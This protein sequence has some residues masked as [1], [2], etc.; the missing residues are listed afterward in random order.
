MVINT[1]T[2]YNP[3]GRVGPTYKDYIISMDLT[4]VSTMRP[5]P[6][7][8]ARDRLGDPRQITLADLATNCPKFSDTPHDQT[9]IHSSGAII[10][11]HPI[12][13]DWNRCNPRLVMPAQMKSVGLPYWR[14]CG[15]DNGH[16][17]IF[18]PPGAVPPVQGIFPTKA[19]APVVPAP[20]VT[21]QP[22]PT[23]SPSP[24]P[25]AVPVA[26]EP[27]PEPEKPENVQQ[28]SKP[29][30]AP[31]PIGQ[32][33]PSPSN[34]EIVAPVN[35]DTPPATPNQ[36]ES[37]PEGPG[38]QPSNPQNPVDQPGDVAAQEPSVIAIIGTNTINAGSSGIVLPGTPLASVGAVAT[39]TDSNNNGVVV[40]VAS[41]GV[42]VGTGASASF[43]ASP[44]TPPSHQNNAGAPAPVVTYNG[45]VIHAVPGATTLVIKGQTLT[46]GGPPVTISGTDNVAI[47][48]N[49]GLI[50]Q[51]PGGTASYFPLPTAAPAQLEAQLDGSTVV[52]EGKTLAVGGP[53]AFLADNVVASLGPSG[54]IIQKPSGIESTIPYAQLTGVAS[55]PARN[56][57]EEEDI[58]GAIA[59]M[60]GIQAAVP[61]GEATSSI[62]SVSVITSLLST[63]VPATSSILTTNVNAPAADVTG[64]VTAAL[65]DKPTPGSPAPE[66]STVL[67]GDET[68][69]NV[70]ANATDVPQNL[71]AS[72]GTRT[73]IWGG[74]CI[75]IA[76]VVI[77]GL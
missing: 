34:P 73:V 8:T 21:A 67:P 14:H 1:L 35:Q 38:N 9:L 12:E 39:L 42:Y 51:Y 22:S 26:P 37:A 60:I 77:L 28:P 33:Q 47:F 72:S 44:T 64:T 16:F 30:L 40:S 15:N 76:L 41:S 10:D 2:A 59:D 65:V 52:Y 69:G 27:Q 5:Y 48:S 7:A 36:S 24:P 54:L 55:A 45:E 74:G 20:V 75:T 19:P 31:N 49:N 13:N 18:D 68:G 23:I 66:V 29:T 46:A 11:E 4:D 6:D 63:G 70:N 50:I 3:C 58:G 61:S 57:A 56:K 32:P 25:T 53:P 17:G 43:I 71:E 62:G